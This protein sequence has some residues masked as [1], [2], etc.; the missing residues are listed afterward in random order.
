MIMDYFYCMRL[1]RR[2]QRGI[3]ETPHLWGCSRPDLV[4]SAFRASSKRLHVT[5]VPKTICTSCDGYS[6]YSG[7][8]DGILQHKGWYWNRFWGK[9]RAVMS[10]CQTFRIYRRGVSGPLVFLI[11]GGGFSALTWAVLSVS[12]YISLVCRKISLLKSSVSALRWIC[13]VMWI[14]NVIVKMIFP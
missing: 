6:D 2:S 3:F 1:L 8:L 4:A 11:H 10:Q 9:W 12:V 5:V 13:V 14:R 7:S